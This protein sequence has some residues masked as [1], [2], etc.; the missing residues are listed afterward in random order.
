MTAILFTNRGTV[1]FQLGEIL[2][3]WQFFFISTCFLGCI[4]FSEKIILPIGNYREALRD[5]E[6]TRKFQPTHPEVTETGKVELVQFYWL[7]H[8]RRILGRTTELEQWVL[9]TFFVTCNFDLRVQIVQT[10]YTVVHFH[11]THPRSF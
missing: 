4:F 6:A 5:A 11:I 3:F 9:V 1:Q 2:H 10:A 7:A 8:S